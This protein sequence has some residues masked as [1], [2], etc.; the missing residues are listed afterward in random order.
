MEEGNCK[1]GKFL[2]NQGCPQCI[3]DRMAA[4]GNTEASVAEAVKK[5][6]RQIV[7]VKFYGDN[8]E[9]KGRGFIYY[10]EEPLEVGQ[11]VKAPIRGGITS[12]LVVEIGIPESEI[13]AFKEL[14]QTIPAGSIVDPPLQDCT[15]DIRAAFEYYLEAD[16]VKTIPAGSRVIG[17]AENSANK[18]E[19]ISIMGSSTFDGDEATLPE[20]V[21]ETTVALRPGEDIEAQD[22]HSQALK[23][24]EY[25]KSRVI[26][27]ADDNK[28][29][30]DDLIAIGKLKT[31]MGKK[32]REYLAPLREKAEAIQETYSTLLDPVIRAD[33]I[34]RDKMLAYAAEQTRK[35][36]AAEAINRKRIEAAQ[37]EMD[38]KG[39]LS[40]SVNLVETPVPASRLT[41]TDLGTSGLTDCW[42]YEVVDP[43]A[44]PEA[45]KLI[46]HVLLNST[47]KKHHDSKPVAGVRFYNEPIISARGR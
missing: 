44:V 4:E 43:A 26:A 13:E 39:E 16:K 40:E 46:D 15:K 30:S 24:L 6:D 37:E 42:K 14:A 36:E 18:G 34:T 45:Y 12:A 32:K 38:L 29:A 2:L 20:Q 23:A 7:K 5:A 8:N 19:P 1:H 33:K 21:A 28:L 9:V 41:R 10:S 3:A 31:A 35:A 17:T 47:A 27:T 25:A 22:Y 11:T